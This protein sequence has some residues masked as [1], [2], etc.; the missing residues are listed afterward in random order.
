MTTPQIFV[1]NAPCSWGVIE[2]IEGERGGYAQVLDEMQE[3][4]YSGTELGDWGFMPTDPEVLSA[5]LARRNLKLLA[6]WVSVKLHDPEAHAASEADALRTARQLAR[7]GGP[8]T[9][10]VLGNDPYVDPVRTRFAGRIGPE[11]GMS[12]AQW[13]ILVEGANRVARAVKRETGLRTVFHHHIGTW[14]ETPEETARLLAMT[15]PEVLGLCFDTGHYRYGGGDPLAGLRRHADRIWHVHFK[16]H[17]PKVAARARAEGWDAVTA[18][19]HGLFCELGQGDIDFPAIL[20]ELKAMKYTGWIVVE[21]DV[22]PGM[23]SPKESAARNRAYL[24][25][26][27]L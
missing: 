21:Q 1:G 22:L 15:D 18:V 26:I 2:N 6:S 11:H 20:A 7:V 5:E 10:V 16:D 9:L 14:I 4:G 24:R 17:D 19:G 27:G 23:G 3:T 25:S 8:D 12:E 13:Q